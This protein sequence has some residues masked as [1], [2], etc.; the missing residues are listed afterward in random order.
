MK[1]HLKHSETMATCLPDTM[2]EVTQVSQ[3]LPLTTATTASNL[4]STPVTSNHSFMDLDNPNSVVV[5]RQDDDV[6]FQ[7]KPQFTEPQ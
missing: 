4:I 6:R 1:R 2:A 3:P 5:L 7:G